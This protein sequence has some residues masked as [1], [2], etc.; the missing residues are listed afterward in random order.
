MS[1]YEEPITGSSVLVEQGRFITVKPS[2]AFPG[3][4]GKK[5]AIFGRRPMPDRI[6]VY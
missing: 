4:S 1:F 5:I 3:F 2:G 6:K